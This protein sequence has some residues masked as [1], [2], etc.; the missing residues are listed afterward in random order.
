MGQSQ[1]DLVRRERPRGSEALSAEPIV[2][3]MLR[4]QGMSLYKLF[5]PEPVS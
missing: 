1:R 4:A 5:D 2:H 3:S